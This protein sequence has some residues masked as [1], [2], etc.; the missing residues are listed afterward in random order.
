[1]IT[2]C[3]PLGGQ[4]EQHLVFISMSM[5]I[6]IVISHMFTEG[7]IPTGGIVGFPL[8]NFSD[9]SITYLDPIGPR[10]NFGSQK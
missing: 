9:W 8:S 5:I 4:H 7:T 1:M 6:H 2:T 10:G 3:L